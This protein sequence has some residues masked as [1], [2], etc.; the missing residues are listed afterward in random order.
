MTQQPGGAPATIL[1]VGDL[2]GGLGRRALLALLPALRAL[3]SP[4]SQLGQTLMSCWSQGG[5]VLTAGNGG[6][7]ADSLH[8]AE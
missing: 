2:V 7:A 8:L 1:F 5:K 6:S 3:Q 4:L